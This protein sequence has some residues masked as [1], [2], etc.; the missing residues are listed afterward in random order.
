MLEGWVRVGLHQFVD[1]I[2]LNNKSSRIMHCVIYLKLPKIGFRIILET[3]QMMLATTFTWYEF[4]QAFIK[5]HGEIS[6]QA[7]SCTYR[8]Q[9]IVDSYR[10]GMAPQHLSKGLQTIFRIDGIFSCY[11]SP[12]KSVIQHDTRHIFHYFWYVNVQLRIKKIHKYIKAIN[13]LNTIQRNL[14]GRHWQS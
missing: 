9:G 13:T 11:I 6:S 12:S 5:H 2:Y 14:L 1:F 7:R 3:W 8:Y 4:N 10:D